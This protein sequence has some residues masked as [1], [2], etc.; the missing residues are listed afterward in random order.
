M[1]VFLTRNTK[2]ISNYPEFGVIR[3][4]FIS[5]RLYLQSKT[6]MA[7]T[8]KIT[9][10]DVDISI[11]NI[12][13]EDYICLTDMVKGKDDNGRAADVI[14]NWIRNRST[15]EFLGTWEQIH[16]SDFKVFEFDN[17]RKSAG[18]PSF[19]LTVKQWTEKTNAIGIV[20]RSGRYGGTYAHKDI[21]FE[22]GSAISPVFKLY[23][24]K[25]YQRLKEA[26]S[27]QYSIEWN[28]KRILSKA[29][30]TLH[31]G[32]V[33]DCIIPKSTLPDDKKGIEHA[34]EA[35]LLNV[36]L[37]GCTAKEWKEANPPLALKGNN[38]RDIASIN[39][40]TVLSNIESLNA[41]LIRDGISKRDR[42]FKLRETAQRQLKSLDDVDFVKS[43]R[44]SYID[45]RKGEQ[46][47]V[48]A[49]GNE[50][51]MPFAGAIKKIVKSGKQ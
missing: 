11:M 18:L 20:S 31:T 23:V 17:F 3:K 38:I 8:K 50:D 44:Y 37:F 2:C 42:L 28:V 24:I 16:N 21:A 19:V 35:D 36:A 15:I 6:P 7:K 4:W 14:R 22:F 1:F 29:N 49:S 32:A 5:I 40:L 47:T 45:L 30:Y 34:K 13:D 51:R 39:E 48:A 33:K 27:N 10:K 26:E 41:E 43:L 9:V 12:G 25:E 46:R